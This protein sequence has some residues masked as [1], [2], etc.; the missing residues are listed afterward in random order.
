[1]AKPWEAPMFS[2]RKQHVLALA[3]EYLIPGRVE[4][5]LGMG[6][7]LVIGRREGYRIWDIDGHELMDLHL[8]GGTY[9]VGHRNPVVLQALETAL[10]TLDVGNHHFPSPARAEL[11]EKLAACTPGDLHYTV[12]AASGSEAVDVAIKSARRFTGRRKI[13]AIASGYHGRTGLSG[14][15]GDDA[16]ARYFSSDYPDEFLKVPFNDL[17]AMRAALGGHDV[18]AVILETIP[19]TYGFPVPSDDYLP[20]VASLCREFGALYIA[21]E[22]QTGLGRTGYLWGVEAWGV[23]PDILITG[24]GLSGGL[25]PV[26]AAVLRKDVGNWLSDNGWGHVTTF[27]GAEPGCVVGSVVLD[28][29]RAPQALA[30]AAEISDYLHAGL[31]DI[32]SRLGFLKDIRRKGLVM[33]LVFDAPTGGMQMMSALYQHGIWAIFAGFD[34]SVLQFKPGLFVDRA[35]CDEALTRFETALKTAKGPR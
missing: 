22:V 2:E 33:G 12:Y 16:T 34:H 10:Q 26:A 18:A 7:P 29:C 13:V 15:A 27:G 14:A 4:A 31:A 21:D 8:N 6:I 9:N 20:G 23:E 25:Y 28:M 17:D 24:K 30:H 1:M 5:F 35:Y 3:H 19:A 32:R 11:A